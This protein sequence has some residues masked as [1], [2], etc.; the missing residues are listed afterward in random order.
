ME[1]PRRRKIEA[2]IDM[3][4]MI[5]TLLQLFLIFLIS[6]S[7]VASAVRLELPKA[8][9]N[10]KSPTEP[11]VVSMDADNQ[12]YLNKEPIAANDLRGRLAELVSN[13]KKQE[14]L[15]RADQ[16]LAYK[17]ILRAIAEIKRAGVENIH[18]AYDEDKSR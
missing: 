9:V 8:S 17:H 13:A 10:Q 1:F 2:H 5:D 15:L 12:M 11:I 6:A 14:V 7:F 18:L 16:S 3:T 4:P